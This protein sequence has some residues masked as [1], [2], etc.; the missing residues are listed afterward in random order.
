MTTPDVSK[1]NLNRRDFLR[2]AFGVGAAGALAACGFSGGSSTPSTSASASSAAPMAQAKVDGDL[3]YYNWA[4]YCE[5]SV[6]SGFKEKYGVN[7]VETNYDGYAGML[8]KIQGGNAYDV[9]LQHL[10]DSATSTAQ[11]QS[12]LCPL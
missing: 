8:A 6:M 10:L 9:E 5:P 7:I 2:G 4:D 11:Q 3:V 1:L 12:H